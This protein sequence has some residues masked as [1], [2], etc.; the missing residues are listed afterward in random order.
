MDG[1]EPIE[2]VLEELAVRALFAVIEPDGDHSEHAEALYREEEITSRKSELEAESLKCDYEQHNERGSLKEPSELDVAED[3]E[4][5]DNGYSHRAVVNEADRADKEEEQNL[6]DREYAFFGDLLFRVIG[7]ECLLDPVEL[8]DREQ[9]EEQGEHH[10]LMEREDKS[11]RRHQIEWN[12]GYQSEDKEPFCVL[13]EI[14]GVN[15]ALGDHKGED[16]EGKPAD[17]G[18]PL[19]IG[20]DGRPKMVEQHKRYRENFECV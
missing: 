12:F 18:H 10:V 13:L 2:G 8:P 9:T 17:A 7:S 14:R 19:V 3:V 11:A 20:N 5:Y 16:R 15:V 6:Q 4:C 1:I